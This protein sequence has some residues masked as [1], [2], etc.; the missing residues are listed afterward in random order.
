MSFTYKLTEKTCFS[1]NKHLNEI[2][3]EQMYQCFLKMEWLNNNELTSLTA[4]MK[5]VKGYS[6]IS[7]PSKMQ[8]VE[9]AFFTIAI[10]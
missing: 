3:K 6:N 7:G 9:L 4:I 8:A 2:I 5:K 10:S 1:L